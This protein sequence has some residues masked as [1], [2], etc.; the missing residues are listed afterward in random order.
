LSKTSADRVVTCKNTQGIA[1]YNTDCADGTA[2]I[3]EGTPV[4]CGFCHKQK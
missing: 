3:A 4:G 2:T 1:P